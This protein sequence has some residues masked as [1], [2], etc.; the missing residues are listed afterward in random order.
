MGEALSDAAPTYE[1][2]DP[3]I[4]EIEK[5]LKTLKRRGKT[6]DRVKWLNYLSKQ[7]F[8]VSES[9][10]VNQGNVQHPPI[11]SLG[12]I[13]CTPINNDTSTDT[14][15]NNPVTDTKTSRYSIS[16]FLSPFF[17]MSYLIHVFFTFKHKILS[18]NF[19]FIASA[20][21]YL[22]FIVQPCTSEAEISLGPLYDCTRIHGTSL[23]KFAPKINCQHNMHLS[24]TTVQYFRANDQKYSPETSHLTIYHCTA[25]QVELTC[26][27]GFSDQHLS[28][29]HST[30]FL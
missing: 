15:L 6:E 18:W 26:K 27:E 30:K 14:P 9:D 4:Y 1:H 3:D 17:I 8:L 24:R 16:R 12:C 20:L 25:E 13:S 7:N 5:I 23:N 11:A 2:A 19:L 21:V 10:M 22:L 29:A 28:I